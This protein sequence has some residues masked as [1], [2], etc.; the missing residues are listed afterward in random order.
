MPTYVYKCPDN[1]IT[2]KILRV[3]DMVQKV[4]CCKCNKPA[5]KII[6]APKTVYVDNMPAYECPVTGEH[7]TSRRQ[8]NELMR[9]NDMVEVGDGKGVHC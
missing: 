7:V 3:A 9:R 4:T 2:E 6:T 1:H 8:R 5:G